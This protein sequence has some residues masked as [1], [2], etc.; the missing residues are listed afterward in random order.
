MELR[1]AASYPRESTS[2]RDGEEL[3]PFQATLDAS[4]D[5]GN[6]SFDWDGSLSLE[7]CCVPDIFPLQ[8]ASS[9]VFDDIGMRSSASPA[10]AQ[11]ETGRKQKKETYADLIYKA[12]IS[13]DAHQMTLK[14]LYQWFIDNTEKPKERQRG[15]KN[16]VRSNLSLNQAFQ[17]LEGKTSRWSLAACFVEGIRP[18]HNYRN[19]RRRNNPVISTKKNRMVVPKPLVSRIRKA[20]SKNLRRPASR[21]DPQSSDGV[22]SYSLQNQLLAEHIPDFQKWGSTATIQAS[23]SMMWDAAWPLGGS[24]YEPAWIDLETHLPWCCAFSPSLGLW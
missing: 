17:R 18:T 6:D 2:I 7:S 10:S 14:D 8:L 1:D 16:S 5:F 4:H 19:S 3:L 22:S 23:Y 21:I 24:K 12:L 13:Q 15:W 20:R 11:A 9:T